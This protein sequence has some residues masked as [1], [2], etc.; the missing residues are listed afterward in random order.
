[1]KTMRKISALMLAIMMIAV[2]G[3]AYGGSV[4]ETMTSTNGVIGA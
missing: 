2:V 3:L 1:M 4:P